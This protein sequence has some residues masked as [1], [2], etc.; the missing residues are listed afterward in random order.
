MTTG[1]PPAAKYGCRMDPFGKAYADPSWSPDSSSV[2]Y[3]TEDGIWQ[4]RFSRLEPNAYDYPG[5]LGCETDGDEHLVVPGGSQ[6]DWDPA[7]PATSRY[8]PPVGGG[9]PNG[10]GGGTPNG[11][12]AGNPGGGAQGNSG[13]SARTITAGGAARQRFAGVLKATCTVSAAGRCRGVA[14]VKVGRRTYASKAATVKVKAG[15][16][17]T[18]K[19]RFSAKAKTAIRRALRTKRLK[20]RVT[21]TSGG[22]TSTR[23]VTLTR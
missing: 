19:L 2:A 6:P 14:K 15:K 10:G 5:S 9:T 18:L 20:A 22:Q 1:M 8:L 3:A 11:G 4:L 16:R 17:A 23:T 12:G 7:D 13:G 21:V